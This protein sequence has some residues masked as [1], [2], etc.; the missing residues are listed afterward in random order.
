MK[1]IGKWFLVTGPL[2]LLG[3]LQ[4][5]QAG[6]LWDGLGGSGGFLCQWF[7]ILC[8]PHSGGGGPTAVPEPEMVMMFGVAVVGVA[9][10][11]VRRRRKK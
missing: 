8:P 5:A 7:G 6:S 10:S 2:L 1:K 11:A 4:S 3:G 9:V